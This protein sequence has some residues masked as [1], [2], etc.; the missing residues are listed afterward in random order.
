MKNYYIENQK[1]FF[2]C[3][4]KGD[5][6]AIFLVDDKG[7]PKDYVGALKRK[8]KVKKENVPSLIAPA[9]KYI[10]NNYNK[11]IHLNELAVL[12]DIS[13]SHLCKVFCNYYKDSIN[14]YIIALRIEKA[15]RLLM[16][17]DKKVVSISQEVGY[18]DSAYFSKLFKKKVGCTPKEYRAMYF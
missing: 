2:E 8:S 3:L 6:L 18:F 7:N 17:S 13:A 11:D 1:T 16:A 5:K 4:K 10:N 15:K 12:C 14:Q 9:V